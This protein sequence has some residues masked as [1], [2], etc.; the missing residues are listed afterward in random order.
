M[1]TISDCGIKDDMKGVHILTDSL[2]I[3]RQDCKLKGDL[4]PIAFGSFGMLIEVTPTPCL[5]L[6]CLLIWKA[7]LK[8]RKC[9]GFGI[10]E[11]L[12]ESQLSH[13]FL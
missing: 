7:R 4:G 13:S 1:V 6:R 11:Y 9:S 10:R 3:V 12:A 2:T 5:I 8:G